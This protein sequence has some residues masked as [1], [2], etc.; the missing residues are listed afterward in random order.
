VRAPATGLPSARWPSRSAGR[1]CGRRVDLGAFGFAAGDVV[2]DFLNGIAAGCFCYVRGGGHGRA[3]AWME[4]AIGEI[5]GRRHEAMVRAGV[6]V[7][8]VEREEVA[9]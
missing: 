7:T 8:E 3:L 6:R 2:C 5:A 4:R 1:S 9:P